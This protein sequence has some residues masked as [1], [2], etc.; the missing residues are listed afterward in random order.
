MKDNKTNVMRILDKEKISYVPHFYEPDGQIDGMHTAQILGIPFEC[1]F[2]T[3]VTYFKKS[4]GKTEHY[5][6]CIPVDAELDLKAAARAAGVKSVEM[7]AVKDLLKTTGYIRG[8]CSPV[9]MKKQFKTFIDESALNSEKIYVSGGKIGAQ[10]ELP[11]DKLA[12]LT[13]AEF[14]KITV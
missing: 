2:K 8:G 9:G 1:C 4:D 3:L 13:G 14:V 6:F 5:V 7:L 12:G 10:V 11:P